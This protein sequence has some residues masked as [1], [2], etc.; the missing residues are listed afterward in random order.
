MERNCGAPV[1]YGGEWPPLGDEPGVA[2][3]F[4]VR[5]TEPKSAA[6][7]GTTPPFLGIKAN[8]Q[9]KSSA[10][11]VTLTAQPVE[12]LDFGGSFD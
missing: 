6:G 7:Q 9:L 10:G 12:T 2:Q 5:Q 11:A 4:L 3:L 8:S 1:V